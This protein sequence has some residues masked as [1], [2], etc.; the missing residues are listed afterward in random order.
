VRRKMI[1][2]PFKGII[3]KSLVFWFTKFF[4]VGVIFI[5]LIIGA[6]YLL[7]TFQTDPE[8]PEEG[9]P[10]DDKVTETASI[11]DV[12][13]DGKIIVEDENEYYVDYVGVEL[14]PADPTWEEI[15]EDWFS[16][17][18]PEDGEIPGQDEMERYTEHFRDARREAQE[19]VRS[20]IGDETS[21]ELTFYRHI[22]RKSAPNTLT[23]E[24]EVNGINIGASLL[25]NGSARLVDWDTYDY[26][27]DLHPDIGEDIGYGMEADAARDRLGIWSIIEDEE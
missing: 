22:G 11:V 7:P 17:Y 23:A 13:E 5:G 6:M 9:T 24:V 8:C 16:H 15:N 3:T 25:E 27:T 18:D 21:A 2:N 12:A 19:H 1:T 10:T 26:Y 4:L 14:I 20:L